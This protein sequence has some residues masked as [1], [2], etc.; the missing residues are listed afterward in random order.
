MI[1]VVVVV[2]ERN[3]EIDLNLVIVLSFIEKFSQSFFVF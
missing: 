1:T 2:G 3:A